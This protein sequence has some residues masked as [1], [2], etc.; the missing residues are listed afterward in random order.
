MLM[1]VNAMKI[2]LGILGSKPHLTI[3]KFLFEG[4][5][6]KEAENEG[7]L[8]LAEVTNI[9][10]WAREVIRGNDFSR[11][12]STMRAFRYRVE[13]IRTLKRYWMYDLIARKWGVEEEDLFRVENQFANHQLSVIQLEIMRWI[14]NPLA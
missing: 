7:V 5:E 8:T 1:K 12:M 2:R 10:R 13:D 6:Y 3:P 11:M 4:F 14:Q 9:F